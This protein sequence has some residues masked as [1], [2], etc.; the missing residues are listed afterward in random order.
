MIQRY[1]SMASSLSFIVLLEPSRALFYYYFIHGALF[2][3]IKIFIFNAK[4]GKLA[5][6]PSSVTETCVQLSHH[7]GI[8]VS[9]PMSYYT[10]VFHHVLLSECH[11]EFNQD[12]KSVV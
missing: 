12:R 9:V 8:L 1:L 5:T 3:L 7:V 10:K 2:P 6:T 4:K 11:L